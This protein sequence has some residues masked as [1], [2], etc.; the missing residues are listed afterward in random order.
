MSDPRAIGN[1]LNSDLTFLAVTAAV[2]IKER[3][4]HELGSDCHRESELLSY[5]SH[6][7]RRPIELV[8]I[9]LFDFDERFGALRYVCGLQLSQGRIS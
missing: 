2:E 4:L 8:R 3:G 5:V 7:H 6:L 9:K 1:N